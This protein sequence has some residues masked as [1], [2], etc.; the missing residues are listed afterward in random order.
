MGQER[1]ASFPVEQFR[2]VDRNVDREDIS[3]QSFYGLQNLWE[4]TVGVLEPRGG[5]TQFN[6][7]FP[8]NIIGLN[9]I[10]RSY[11]SKTESYRVVGIECQRDIDYA[12]T[13]ASYPNITVSFAASGGAGRY[14]ISY[15]S[16]FQTFPKKIIL[17]LVGYGVNRVITYDAT[18]LPGYG[19][20]N[21]KLVVDITS[22]F[23]DS[24]ITGIEVL[25]GVNTASTG[26]IKETTIY[27]WNGFIPVDSAGAYVT[28][29]DFLICPLS[30]DFTQTAA[31]TGQT[32]RTFTA[33]SADIPGGTL[34]PGKTYY[35]LWSAHHLKSAVSNNDQRHCYISP[36]INL[37]G[38]VPVTIQEGHNAISLSGFSIATLVA[39]MFIGEHRQLMQPV[40][41]T[42]GIS[43]SILSLPQTSPALMDINVNAAN[44]YTYS[45][46]LSD[47]SIKDMFI[48]I[49]DSGAFT[50][51]FCSRLNWSA[52]KDLNFGNY[53]RV[54]DPINNG[55]D[56]DLENR[57]HSLGDGSL[58]DFE[59][60]GDFLYFV[61]A[62]NPKLQESD[63][64]LINVYYRH[65]SGSNYY[66][67]GNGI[68]GACIEEN[69][70]SPLIRLP[71]FTKIFKYQES[72]LLTGGSASSDIITGGSADSSRTV[73]FS[74]TFNPF[75]FTI[76][77][78][79]TPA[80]QFFTVEQGGEEISGLGLFSVTTGDS[81]PIGQLVVGKRTS[82]WMISSLP[83][84]DSGSLPQIFLNNVTRK[85][86]CAAHRSFVNTPIGLISAAFDNVY[87]LRDSGEPTPLGD[88]IRNILRGADLSRAVASY[89]DSQ[90]KLSF[91]HPDYPGAAGFNNVE[92]WLDVNKVKILQ[93]QP[94]W[95]GPMVGRQIDGQIIEDLEGD[96]LTYDTSRDRVC[97]DRE[98]V[99]VFKADVIPLQTDEVIYDFATPVQCRLESKDF[100]VSDQD[101]NW[102]KVLKRSYWKARVVNTIGSPLQATEETYADGVLVGTQTVQ[103]IG[104]TLVD[105]DKQP[106]ILNRVFPVGRP[107]GRTFRK[108][109]TTNG[110]IGIGGFAINYQVER[111]RI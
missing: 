39:C 46:R 24:N 40:G 20:A 18:T 1:E 96:G 110:R 37:S 12:L 102:N 89:H 69:Y 59:Q 93:G 35:V 77:G 44:D 28:T 86:G 19:V 75:D 105:F 71:F 68:S 4:R 5:S 53:P 108:V 50:P 47:F 92:F 66:I 61:N 106:L 36:N 9:G 65:S 85:A 78:A 21:N 6:Q 8:S 34:V 82:F 30:F 25:A 81:G 41:L 26:A 22:A 107:R 42:E 79:G 64:G 10:A 16:G 73:Y 99:R 84:A 27:I 83:V 14:F 13:P 80:Y 55:S 88:P 60:F 111:R 33:A 67:C 98:N 45:F 15:A 52:N 101:N 17:R 43:G 70:A 51:I 3:P 91:Y 11:R 29:H 103:F 104:Q 31:E 97:I 48:R 63:Y 49:D 7:P 109:L 90:Y 2:G 32:A 54:I 62:F 58:L 76:A 38:A 100:E 87:V 74:R 23:A 72:I 94:D 95:K 56:F 57:F